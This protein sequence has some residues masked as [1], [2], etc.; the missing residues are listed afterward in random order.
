MWIFTTSGQLLTRFGRQGYYPGEFHYPYGVALDHDGYIYISESGNHR[1]SK[2]T[3]VGKLVKCFGRKGSEPGMFL[4]PRHLCVD[5]QGQLIVADEQN[6]R[7]Q[8]F[9]CSD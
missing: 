3:A 7:L 4:F 2:F 9:S 6:Q 5:S 8:I 1:I